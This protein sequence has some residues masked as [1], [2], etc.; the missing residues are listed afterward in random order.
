MYTQ[1]FLGIGTVK[2][3]RRLIIIGNYG[4][5]RNIDLKECNLNQRTEIKVVF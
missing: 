1:L 4:D 3:V 5:C 2:N